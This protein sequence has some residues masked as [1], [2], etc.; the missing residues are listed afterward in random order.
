MR[1]VGGCRPVF[2]WRR[3]TG[4]ASAPG[5]GP[6]APGLWA[7][8]G[9]PPSLGQFVGTE[10]ATGLEV[11]VAAGGAAQCRGSVCV[12]G[13]AEL[14]PLPARGCCSR[15]VC[16]ALGARTGFGPRRPVPRV[17]GCCQGRG[18]AGTRAGRYRR[19]GV[20]AVR[21]L[22]PPLSP[23]LHPR[24]PAERPRSVRSCRTKPCS[25]ARPRPPPLPPLGSVQ[26]LASPC[27]LFCPS[28]GSCLPCPGRG[29]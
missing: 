25:L 5:R 20:R 14:G 17:W 4:G 6:C 9:A 1:P 16:P 22:R 18:A 12:R 11:S 23:Q 2:G 13:V 24:C 3:L 7:G 15:A 26:D 28:A 27:C 29:V 19:A 21:G 10:T 8:A